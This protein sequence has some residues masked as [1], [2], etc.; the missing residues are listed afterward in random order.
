VQALHEVTETLLSATGFH[1]KD[2]IGEGYRYRMT[3]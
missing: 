1:L 2:L 3:E